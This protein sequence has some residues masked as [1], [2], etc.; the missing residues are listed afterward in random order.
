M[1]NIKILED[2]ISGTGTGKYDLKPLDIEIY[3]NQYKIDKTAYIG[4]SNVEAPFSYIQ[5][6]DLRVVPGFFYIHDREFYLYNE[7]ITQVS[8]ATLDQEK[9]LYK[10]ELKELPNGAGTINFQKYIDNELSSR[11]DDPTG[12]PPII[13]QKYPEG[14]LSTLNVVF[15]EKISSRDGLSDGYGYIR[16]NG[17][18]KPPSESTFPGL[19]DPFSRF[20]KCPDH[21]YENEHVLKFSDYYYDI[22][23]NSIYLYN[24]DPN[25]EYVITFENLN[26]PL[27]TRI[28]LNPLTTEPGNYTLVITPQE[29]EQ[30]PAQIKITYSNDTTHSEPIAICISIKDS[31]NNPIAN[32][33]V[34]V[35]LISDIIKH[36]G[37]YIVGTSRKTKTFNSKG[38][39][40]DAISVAEGDIVTFINT[41][42]N[43][44]S[45]NIIR[46]DFLI[47]SIGV[48]TDRDL[49]NVNL[50]DFSMQ[51]DCPQP[52]ISKN[53]DNRGNI[54]LNY[55]PP[56][57]FKFDQDISVKVKAGDI[58]NTF[59]IKLTSKDW[60]RYN[61]P[62]LKQKNIKIVP[63][64]YHY[65]EILST[66]IIKAP[67]PESTIFPTTLQAQNKDEFLMSLYHTVDTYPVEFISYPS[68]YSY[69]N[70]EIT[71]I[72]T[73]LGSSTNDLQQDSVLIV[74]N[75]TDRPTKLD[76]R[77]QYEY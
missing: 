75:I 34:S 41:N 32:Y 47:P 18:V 2:F 55:Y 35:E 21:W 1:S 68:D 28:D 27:R 9:G 51:E 49:R 63:S 30:I 24:G 4:G 31:N 29:A 14:T 45:N 38:P 23:T 58:T 12:N 65:D 62:G 15:D 77:G 67:A 56:G 25:S 70:D 19:F 5:N 57:D 16:E 59:I 54:F 6:I 71:L 76:G 17:T 20:E 26:I 42:T 43:I 10:I 64:T 11:F 50:Y 48:I 66:L 22:K 74:Y 13:V 37:N 33:E 72:F 3:D 46:G 39:K 44:S 53:T 69:E 7:K 52:F 8:K 40:Y 60:H 73:Q 61:I 36:N